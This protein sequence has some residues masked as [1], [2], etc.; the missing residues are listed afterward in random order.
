MTTRISRRRR[1]LHPP[2]RIP[3]ISV[4]ETLPN[5]ERNEKWKSSTKIL[6]EYNKSERKRERVECYKTEHAP[7]TIKKHKTT[8]FPLSHT[9]HTSHTHTYVYA[10]VRARI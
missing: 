7:E 6:Y 4:V 2:S 9:K 3:S 1:R 5:S 10:T 8:T